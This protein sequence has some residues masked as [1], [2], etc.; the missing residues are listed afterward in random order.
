MIIF[1]FSDQIKDGDLVHSLAYV[2]CD[3]IGQMVHLTSTTHNIRRAYFCGGFISEEFNREQILRAI[4]FNNAKAPKVENDT[5]F[6][7]L[8]IVGHFKI[9]VASR[10]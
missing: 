5:F 8:L 10:L 6:P 7:A 9:L 1:H 2:M 4:Y 3:N